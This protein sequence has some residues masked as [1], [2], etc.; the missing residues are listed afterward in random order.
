MLIGFDAVSETAILDAMK[1][2]DVVKNPR[3]GGFDVVTVEYM[4]FGSAVWVPRR[5]G[6]VQSLLLHICQGTNGLIYVARNNGRSRVMGAEYDFNI[7][8]YYELR[9]A[10]V[11]FFADMV[12]HFTATR[13]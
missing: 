9:G 2:G 12:T 5:Q 10:F 13:W 4:Y 6:V 7:M 1:F 3:A 11:L 8:F